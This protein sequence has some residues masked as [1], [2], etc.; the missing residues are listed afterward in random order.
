MSAAVVLIAVVVVLFATAGSA[1]KHVVRAQVSVARPIPAVESGVLPW[2]LPAPI[3]REVVLPG[4]GASVVLLGGLNGSTS[5]SGVFTLDTT[6]GALRSIGELKA[7]VH[8][9]AGSVA[10]GRYVVFGGGSPTTVASV[11]A[12]STGHAA[13][14]GA[15]P[16]PRS[17]ATAVSVGDTTY[18]VGGYTGTYSDPTVLATT[19]GVKFTA[20]A[21]LRVPV[22]YPAVAATAGKLYVFGGQAI[23][24]PQ[25]GLPVNDIQEVDLTKHSA[26]VVG[27]LPEPLQASAAVEISGNIYLAG[28]DTTTPQLGP[29]GVGSANITVASRAT[30]SSKL[31]T[32][33]T[34]WAFEPT[35]RRTLIAGRLEVPVSHAGIAVVGDHAWVI[36]GES[37]GSQVGA[38]Q[39]MTPNAAF[40]T[41]GAPG[42]GSPYFGGKLLI[43]DRGNNRLL[44]LDSSDR[45]VWRFP[46]AS[47]GRDRF[48]FVY[49]D[50]AFF[51]HHGT[52]IISNQ[53]QQDTIE[54]LAFPSGKV[55]WSYGHP[56]QP[57][58]DPGYLHEP[59][60]AYLLKDGRIT[61]ADAQNCRVLVINPN[62][63][64]ADHI[65]TGAVCAHNPPIS[66]GSPNGDTPLA[67]GDLLISEINGS[68]IDELTPAGHTVWSVQLP[69]SYPSD[70]QQLGPDLYLLADYT[71]PGQIIEFNRAGKILYRY[72]IASGPGML[73]QPSLVEQLPSGVFMANDDYRDRM[74]AIDPSTQALVWQYGNTDKSGTAA[75]MLNTP[76]GFD[77]LMNNGSTPTHP[78]TG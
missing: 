27:R 39:M 34:I 33:A 14:L 76:D 29:S 62:H 38:V 75:G 78:T 24:G 70:P 19:D 74:V 55:I 50:D 72:D 12:F 16:S 18:I 10:N 67:N 53:E 40:G 63:T 77:V 71:T 64:V 8:D 52:A 31:F 44:L 58:L 21:R 30:G 54:E 49:P 1:G 57:G 25:A 73:N 26:A 4:R 43:A 51:I 36:G 68:W 69:I 17:D 66:L 11:E 41:A 56:R 5:A 3:S 47:S 60:D 28:G 2:R 46:S 15:L 59:D 23:S 7:G 42:A 22:R 9:A 20:A 48:G 13:Q 37:G 35:S 65:G 6:S 32:T 61:V 45:V